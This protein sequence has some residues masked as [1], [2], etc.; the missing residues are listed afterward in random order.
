VLQRWSSLVAGA[1]A[2]AVLSPALA[3]PRYGVCT[4]QIKA[5]VERRFGQA[6]TEIDYRLDNDTDM[7]TGFDGETNEAIVYVAEC[8]G[9]YWY[10]VSADEYTCLDRPHYGKPPTYVRFRS[11]NEGC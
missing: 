8:P 10:E 4:D 2:L 1:L 5:D 11:A 9:Y 7:T 3:A 6:V